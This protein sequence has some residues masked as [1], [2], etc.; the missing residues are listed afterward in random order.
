MILSDIKNSFSRM[1]KMIWGKYM[2]RLLP[3]VLAVIIIMDVL[4]F[5]AV[6]STNERNTELMAG[7]SIS[8]QAEAIDQLLKSYFVELALIRQTYYA[9]SDIDTFIKTAKDML[10]FSSNKWS[11]V[12][13]T[14]LDGRSY[15]TEEGLSKMDGRK[16][17]FYKA[18][19]NDNKPFHLQR[20]FKSHFN[21]QD[22]WCLTI[23]VRDMQGDIMCLMSAVF[24]TDEIDGMMYKLK[25]NGEG[26]S[27]ITD[28]DNVFR[29]YSDTLVDGAKEPCI[30]ELS[31][32]EMMSMG[33][34]SLDK[35]VEQ[36]WQSRGSVP[37]ASGHYETPDGHTVQSYMCAIGE[38]DLVVC[39]SIPMVR[40]HSNTI[41]VGLLLA[42]TAI[43]TVVIIVVVVQKVT[44]K[45][46]IEPVK[47]LNGFAGDFKEGRL[48]SSEAMSITSED[49]FGILKNNITAMQERMF[50]AVSSIRGY[51]HEMA[52]GVVTLRDAVDKISSD[53]RRQ[54]N[55]V[56]DISMSM[57]TIS[58]Y[59]QTN[60]ENTAQTKEISDR[61]S[62]DIQ[63]VTS[64]TGDTVSCI[65]NVISKVE[66]I[67]E[68]TSRTDLLAINAAVEAARAGEN[69]KGFAVVAAE[70][71]NLAEHCQVASTE[72][73]ELS[74]ECLNITQRSAELIHNMSPR[75]QQTADKIA[76]ISLSCSE[77]FNL[78]LM[79]SQTLVQLVDITSNNSQ[80]ADNL[81]N[82]A[83]QL[84]DIFRRLN[85][86]VEFFKLNAREAQGKDFIMKEIY[87]H[88]HEI[89]KLKTELIDI[90]TSSSRGGGMEE[91]AHDAGIATQQQA[92]D[93]LNSISGSDSAGAKSD[94]PQPQA[95]ETA[96]PAPINQSRKPGV[97]IDLDDFD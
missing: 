28:V 52:A 76:E 1:P 43:L 29:I 53:A 68:I 9:D 79:I 6:K 97:S 78:A 58:K 7:Q 19:V 3:T 24:P 38:T 73:N 16:T 5:L 39:L 89:M 33:Y 25:A 85:V 27:S 17:R 69:G 18:I 20:P 70:I 60:N 87:K 44:Q 26:Y 45:V 22:I 92:S 96:G 8:L 31:L 62:E 41:T 14:Y 74:A 37:Y 13:V 93:A 67:N 54:S 65:K 50:T 46:V 34:T 10:Y 75:I 72:I 4:I 90:M 21:N 86:S 82:Y 12:R 61:I 84:N 64:A 47:A 66:V 35:L 55:A 36:G 88:S 2:R 42:L 51:I 32:Q 48:Y 83:T 91:S 95:E 49:E 30:K 57:D 94:T 63:S 59:V 11:Y 81:S 23:P 77:Q 56:L 71:R 40:L 15:T 80:S